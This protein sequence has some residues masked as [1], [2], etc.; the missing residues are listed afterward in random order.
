[1]TIGGNLSMKPIQ[2]ETMYEGIGM[3]GKRQTYSPCLS[4]YLLIRSDPV[5]KLLFS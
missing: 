4:V 3:Y 1:M 5:E 2:W